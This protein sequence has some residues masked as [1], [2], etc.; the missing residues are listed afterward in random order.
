MLKRCRGCGYSAE[1]RWRGPCPGCGGLWA[2]IAKEKKDEKES[3]TLGNVGAVPLKPRVKTGISELDRILNGGIPKGST[4][5]I[6]G[7][8]GVGKTSLLLLV[9]DAVASE[10]RPVTYAAGEQKVDDILEYAQRL[11]V[12]NEH[13]H[14]LGNEGDIYKITEA[15]EERGS[16]L[17]II[18]SLQTAAC[19]DVSADEGSLAQCTAVTQYVTAWGKR[20][21][22]AVVIVSHVNKDGDIA[23]PKT[24]EH[25]VDGTLDFDPAP[26][27]DADGEIIE[28]TANYRTLTTSAK[29]RL[30]PSHQVATFNMTAEGKLVPVRRRSKLISIPNEPDED[31]L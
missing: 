9:G 4:I 22:I 18:D 11:G 7:P 27:Y 20:T 5:I 1:A 31:T 19:E 15:A 29:F 23:G 2:I 30:G 25:L 17:V 3:T 21:D 26:E 6:N 10:R 16:A 12:K 28:R 24:V 13:I 14:V 8:P